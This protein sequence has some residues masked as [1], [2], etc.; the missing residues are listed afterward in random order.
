[1]KHLNELIKE[2]HYPEPNFD[3]MT[4]PVALL[5]LMSGKTLEEVLPK[6]V[7]WAITGVYNDHK[8]KFKDVDTK[9]LNLLKD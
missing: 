6:T 4:P 1:M 9:L 3:R 2:D 7:G 8:D 5:M